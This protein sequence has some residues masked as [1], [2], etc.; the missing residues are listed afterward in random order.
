MAQAE[1]GGKVG[2]LVGFHASDALVGHVGRNAQA[3][4][5]YKEA[6]HLVDGPGMA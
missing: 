5:F 1:L 6:L 2:G 4:L 3:G